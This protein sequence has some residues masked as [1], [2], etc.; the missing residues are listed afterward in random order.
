MNVRNDINAFKGDLKSAISEWAEEKVNDFAMHHPALKPVSVYI[1]RGINHWLDSKDAE[2]NRAIDFA[3][4]CICDK[5]GNFDS[6]QLIDDLA[7]MFRLM[8]E[9]PIQMGPL[10]MVIGKGAIMAS[11][12]NPLADMLLGGKGIRISVDEMLELKE[13]L[14]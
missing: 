7:D 8:D 14:K 2:I 4:P 10:N 11:I 6:D 12:D 9:H 3:V 13:I 5:H 1:K